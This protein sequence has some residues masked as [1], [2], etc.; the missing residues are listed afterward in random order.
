MAHPPRTRLRKP[1]SDPT[2][3]APTD[4]AAEARS[5]Q[6]ARP[7]RPARPA[8]EIDRDGPVQAVRKARPTKGPPPAQ[9]RPHEP[10]D[11]SGLEA[12]A[13]MDPADLA[14]LMDAEPLARKL[15]EGQR[16]RATVVR[17]TSNHLLLDVG[18]K[19]EAQ[20]DRE[21]L[22]GAAVG[23]EVEA[24]VVFT[25]GVDTTLSTRLRGDAAAL[26]LDQA[27]ENEIPVEGVV[28]RRNAGGF[29]VRV[30][31]VRA[32]CPLRLIDRHPFG[33]LDHYQ[34]QTLRFLVLET[35]DKV[36]LSRRALQEQGLAESVTQRW[37]SVAEGETLSGVVT[38]IQDFG[39]FV[40]C[41][42]LEGLVPRSEA[43]WERGVELGALFELGQQVE[44]RVLAVDRDNQK[45]TFSVKDP[46]SAP[47]GRVGVEFI[48]GGVYAGTVQNVEDYGAFVVLA[49]GIT[50]MLHRS[51]VPALPTA[52]DTVEVKVLAIDHSRRRIELGSPSAQTSETPAGEHVRGTVVEVLRNGVVVGLD[53]G[54]TGWLPESEAD[55]PPGKL[56][57]QRFRRG[58]V[59]EAKVASVDDRRDRVTL[60]QRSS[61]DEESAR[62]WRAYR[63]KTDE[64]GFGTLGD[65]LGK[66]KK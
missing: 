42:G 8:D 35:G 59:I 26:F 5:A 19:A 54:R 22:P 3:A 39:V 15:T 27:C 40:D 4:P 16:V 56:L 49:P 17:L 43:S 58:R 38:G 60:T 6:A 48:V 52:G 12:L 28:E 46:G 51:A 47:W 44:V 10:L 11:L 30:G 18:L 50:G 53:D 31:D 41:D 55:V 32:F 33:D 23:D 64:G 62:S 57:A 65:L 25:D 61:T 2:D 7:A 1:G 13:S 34:G 21:E 9:R 24:F 14:S 36:V 66:L 37:A 63:P 45:L 29:T 20:L